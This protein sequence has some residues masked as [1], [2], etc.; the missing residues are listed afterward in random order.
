[1]R[2]RQ[3]LTQA[4]ESNKDCSATFPTTQPSEAFVGRITIAAEQFQTNPRLQRRIPP[5]VLVVPAQPFVP[6]ER[7]EFHKFLAHPFAAA[8]CQRLDDR[9]FLCSRTV[10]QGL[11]HAIE[12]L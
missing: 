5:N 7:L 1:V 2:R 10:P 3:I 9:H 8:A 6:H 4:L 12:K 11:Q